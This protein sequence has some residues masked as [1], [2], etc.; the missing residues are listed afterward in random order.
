MTK[1]GSFPGTV[2]Q[3][4]QALIDD[5]QSHDNATASKP[6]FDLAPSLTGALDPDT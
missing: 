1:L 5:G 2:R 3:R 4:T 6:T